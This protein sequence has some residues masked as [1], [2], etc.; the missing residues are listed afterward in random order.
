MINAGIIV[1][2]WR[3]E[4]HLE[5]L[6]GKGR[7]V[8]GFNFKQAKSPIVSTPKHIRIDSKDF[9]AVKEQNGTLHLLNRTGKV[10]GKH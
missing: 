9:I 5:M 2:Y 7:K 6:D 10:P 8:K 1:L 3:R 4:K